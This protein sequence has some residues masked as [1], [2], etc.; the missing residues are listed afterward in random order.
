ME[1]TLKRR[2]MERIE[3]L[4]QEIQELEDFVF[5]YE[6]VSHA[7]GSEP[8]EAGAAEIE[9]A[10]EKP[11]PQSELH[12]LARKALRRE[13][14]PLTTAELFGILAEQGAVVGGKNP[15][16]NLGAK[17]NYAGDLKNTKGLGWWFRDIYVPYLLKAS[18]DEEKPSS[19]SD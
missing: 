6:K 1:P 5:L 18:E 16:G 19:I 4:R 3:L 10:L 17:L 9:N 14:R 2:A 13:N 11:T 7:L 12:E 15:I 8:T